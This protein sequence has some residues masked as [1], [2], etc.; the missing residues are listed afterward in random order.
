M[1]TL[2][3]MPL[4][5]LAACGKFDRIENGGFTSVTFHRPNE[6]TAAALAGGIFI[7][8]YS[9]TYVANVKISD[10]SQ[11]A[12]LS[13]PNGVY[14]F[15]A[16]GYSQDL[17]TSGANHLCAIAG[18]GA[19]IPLTGAAQ[20]I[21]LQ[22]NTANCAQGSFGPPTH[23]EGGM[24]AKMESV[25]CSSAADLSSSAFTSGLMSCSGYPWSAPAKFQWVIPTF[26]SANGNFSKSGEAFRSSCSASYPNASGG[27]SLT[28]YE[29]LPVGS[30]SLPGLFPVEVETFSETACTSV[31][32][33]VHR[34]H[35]G[36]I[37]GPA[38]AGSAAITPT[39]GG[40]TR[41]RIY[42]RQ[43]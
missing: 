5:F 13:L 12:T 21:P 1:R 9:P 14:S 16:Y 24:F 4:L 17:S 7:Y 40:T 43:M 31:P 37:F 27:P 30:L 18:A 42:L 8:A 25:Y 20:T 6:P 28:Q 33:A 29:R 23:L 2:L 19:P 32:I 36:L 39:T 22:F 38:S 15:Y 10:E 3:L 35:K 34:F 11:E 26:R 41:T